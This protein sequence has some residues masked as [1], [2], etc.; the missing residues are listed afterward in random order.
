MIQRGRKLHK[1]VLNSVKAVRCLFRQQFQGEEF[2]ESEGGK[3]EEEEG[4]AK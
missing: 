2:G 3:E 1:D 4:G